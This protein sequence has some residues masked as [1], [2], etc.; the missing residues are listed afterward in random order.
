MKAHNFE[1]TFINNQLIA[2]MERCCTNCKLGEPE[3]KNMKLLLYLKI[4]IANI[5]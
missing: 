1:K 2:R 3:E 4:I 5:S